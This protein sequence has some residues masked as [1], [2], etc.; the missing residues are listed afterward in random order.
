MHYEARVQAVVVYCAEFEKRS[1]KK[2]T[3]RDIFLT[4]DQY[5]RVP[6]NWCANKAECWSMMV[7][8]WIREDW[9]RQHALC[10][11]RRLMMPGPAHHQGSLSLSEYKNTW[12]ESHP[13]QSCNNFTAYAMS[14]MGRVTSDVAYNPAAPPEAYTNPSIHAR[15]NAYT[16]V[17]RALHG[18]TWDPTTAPL[19]GEAIMRAGQGK[20]HGRYLIANS[21]VDTASTPSLSQLRASTTDSTPPIRPRPETSVASVHQRQAEMEAKFEEERRCRLEIEAKLEQERKLR[22]E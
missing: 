18:E 1:V 20:K 6:P 10:R 5:L 2:P 13:G 3:A 4:R 21:L 19:S 16:E 14:H 7:D 9:A 11:E 8:K 22:E 17:G 15:I 12:S